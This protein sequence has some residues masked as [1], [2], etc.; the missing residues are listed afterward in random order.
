M[1][2]EAAKESEEMRA[3]IEAGTYRTDGDGPD[4]EKE[5]DDE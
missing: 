4:D 1:G 2:D 3:A 5:S